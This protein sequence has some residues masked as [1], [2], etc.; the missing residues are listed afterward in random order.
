MLLLLQAI[1]YLPSSAAPSAPR[2]VQRQPAMGLRW[3]V[4]AWVQETCPAFKLSH[5][6]SSQSPAAWHSLQLPPKAAQRPAD[7]QGEPPIGTFAQI[8]GVL[9]TVCKLGCHLYGFRAHMW[10]TRSKMRSGQLYIETLGE[11]CV[12]ENL[13]VL[14][15]QV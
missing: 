6:P 2:Q 13:Q 7:L 12:L 5:G 11:L 3:Q 15:Q 4:A 9:C 1:R 14:I 8:S 10:S